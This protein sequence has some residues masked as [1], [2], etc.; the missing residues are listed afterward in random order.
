MQLRRVLTLKDLDQLFKDKLIGSGTYSTGK[1]ALKQGRP[2][3]VAIT[4]DA[5]NIISINK[6]D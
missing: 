4:T 1:F 5:H 6:E 2:L 3:F